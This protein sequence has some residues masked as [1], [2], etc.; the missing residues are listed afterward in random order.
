[1]NENLKLMV[2]RLKKI[3]NCEG[4]I[5]SGSR[6]EG[7]FIES[8]DYDFTVLISQGRSYY[9]IFT[10]KD[11]IIDIC[12]ATEKVIKEHD[13]SNSKVS[14]PELGI[15]ANGVILFDK[16]GKML[17]LQKK[18]KKVWNN[19]PKKNT[20]KDL[21]EITSLLTGFFHKLSKQG[22]EDAYTFSSEV[23]NKTI[24]I[25]FQLHR[26]WQPKPFN[27]EDSI[28]EIDEIFF[29][30][31]KEMSNSTGKKKIE[32]MKKMILYLMD[33]FSLEKSFDLYFVKSEN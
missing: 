16:N 11:F 28:R 21:Q 27:I 5:Y 2:G 9:K 6:L 26:V 8:S 20:Q 14:N 22:A 17:D 29:N 3:P 25:F 7:D 10:Y 23:I 18:A 33:K 32:L 30:L 1:M 13:I 4:I 24:K 12:C 31:Y 19:G 15:I